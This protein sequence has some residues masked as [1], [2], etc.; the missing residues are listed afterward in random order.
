M[1]PPG[2]TGYARVRYSCAMAHGGNS[3]RFCAMPCPRE[4]SIIAQI[5]LLYCCAIDFGPI[6]Q[7]QDG[8]FPWQ[9]LRPFWS[10]RA[11]G[12]S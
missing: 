10:F 11:T 3:A 2:E 6:A 1:E 9:T 5:G 12:S 7:H 4:K 8:R